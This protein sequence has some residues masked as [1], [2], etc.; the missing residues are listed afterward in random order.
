M[1]DAT[2]KQRVEDLVGAN[3][4]TPS[5]SSTDGGSTYDELLTR[6]MHEGVRDVVDRTLQH[7]PKDMHLFCQNLIIRDMDDW[8]ST[9]N[10]LK[11]SEYTIPWKDA[12]GGYFIDNNYILWVS[13]YFGGIK[14]PAHEISAEKGL[15]VEDPESI[16]YTG[17]DFRNPVWYRS[18]SKIYVYPEVTEL[19][20][21]FCSIVKFDSSTTASGS[22]TIPYFP[23]HLLFLV[24]L[25]MATKGLKLVKSQARATYVKDY[26]T[27]QVTWQTLYGDDAGI[28]TPPAFPSEL[29]DIS[30]TFNLPESESV[31]G[32]FTNMWTRINTD[33]EVELLSAEISRFNTILSEYNN[34]ISVAEKQHA[35]EL[36]DFAAKLKDF[37]T[38]YQTVMDVWT[39]YQQSFQTQT[40]YLDAE[41]ARLERDYMSYFYPKHYLDKTKE[42]GNY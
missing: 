17:N 1:A 36:G 42:E 6:Y 4:V 37:T 8:G 29:T 16:Y 21:G 20:N 40:A 26:S 7:N 39:K 33:E 35:I 9:A 3:F 24:V 30:G 25:Y 11:F 23:D 12:D 32:T 15:K 41:I 13:R 27:P 14:V 2:I 22:K 31:V 5:S 28:P 34:Q 10:T 18:S 19:E 38:K